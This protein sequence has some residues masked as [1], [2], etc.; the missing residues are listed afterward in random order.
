MMSLISAHVRLGEQ[1]AGGGKWFDQEI[2]GRPWAGT[3]DQTG[4]PR[5][6]FSTG[7]ALSGS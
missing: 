6:V 4:F 2:Q 1:L 5:G 7:L 3:A